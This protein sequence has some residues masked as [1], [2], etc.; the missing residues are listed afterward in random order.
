MNALMN[1]S[2]PLKP[3]RTCAA[4]QSSWSSAMQGVAAPSMHAGLQSDVMALLMADTV[5]FIVVVS[6]SP[7]TS[8]SSDAFVVVHVLHSNIRYVHRD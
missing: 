2:Y 8:A 7:S 6:Q 5:T 3:W 1:E 4:A